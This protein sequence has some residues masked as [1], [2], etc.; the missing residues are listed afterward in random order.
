[1]IF[2]TCQLNTGKVASI[3]QISYFIIRFKEKRQPTWVVSAYHPDFR[4]YIIAR[5]LVNKANN[6]TKSAEPITDQTTG[7]AL[8]PTL[9]ERN[10][11]KPK[12]VAIQEPIT[13]PTNPTRIEVIQPPTEYPAN[14]CPTAPQTAAMMRRMRKS[15]SVISISFRKANS[16]IIPVK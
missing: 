13:A 16:A 5:L 4:L 15:N 2:I 14:A 7:N 3:L 12:F 6:A 8:P 10:S 1:M 11:G 9:T